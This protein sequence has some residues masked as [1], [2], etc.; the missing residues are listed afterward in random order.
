MNPIIFSILLLS[1]PFS[2]YPFYQ[3]VK[4]SWFPF[5]TSQTHIVLLFHWKTRVL[6]IHCTK[7][8]GFCNKNMTFS[9]L[10]CTVYCFF[11]ILGNC[12]IFSDRRYDNYCSSFCLIVSSFSL[13]L[14]T[15][16]RLC[17]FFLFSV[18]A[19]YILLLLYVLIHLWKW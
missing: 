15:F 1:M 18:T 10:H 13:L 17:F 19:S 5:F 7:K 3:Y 2:C 12:F 6:L 11:A 14:L 9:G 16:F 4:D 8:F